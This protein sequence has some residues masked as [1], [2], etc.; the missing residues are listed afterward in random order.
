MSSFDLLSD[1]VVLDVVSWLTSTPDPDDCD[2]GCDNGGGSAAAVA[3]LA[4]LRDVCHL[5]QTCR[6]LCSLVRSRAVWRLVDLGVVLC[7]VPWCT[8]T[9]AADSLLRA[10]QIAA[11]ERLSQVAAL[12]ADRQ[13]ALL[14]A[15]PHLR[16]L[17]LELTDTAALSVV[18]SLRLLEWLRLSFRVSSAGCSVSF[19]QSLRF[20]EV[21]LCDA[22]SAS[23]FAGGP[24]RSV[25]E[26]SLFNMSDPIAI[27][28]A[29]AAFPEL[30]SLSIRVPSPSNFD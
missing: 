24:F 6:R 30:T 9:R 2:W 4:Q 17:S 7:A 28:V 3:T 8:R 12:P 26:L 14:S 27:S 25:R 19:P 15:L 22:A 1:W 13:F 16:R 18:S 11:C 10:P 29:L 21:G 20:L 23:L 5:G